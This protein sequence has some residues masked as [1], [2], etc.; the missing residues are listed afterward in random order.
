MKSGLFQAGRAV[1]GEKLIVR[2]NEPIRQL[3][4][5]TGCVLWDRRKVEVRKYGKKNI[6]YRIMNIECRMMKNKKI[7]ATNKTNRNE[8]GRE[9]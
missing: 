5:E 9:D 8:Q 3:V 4:S 7:I 2:G 6:E 1:V